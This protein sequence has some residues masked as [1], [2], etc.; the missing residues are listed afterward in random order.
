[1]FEG[2]SCRA[3]QEFF[4]LRP[5]PVSIPKCLIF[6]SL[7]ERVVRAQCSELPSWCRATGHMRSATFRQITR[8]Y[9]N[10]PSVPTIVRQSLPQRILSKS[11]RA[12]LA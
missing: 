8:R 11:S 10:R 1:M 12:R 9:C 2:S 5:S 7:L 4:L 3:L 6:N